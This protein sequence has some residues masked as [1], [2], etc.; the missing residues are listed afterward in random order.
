VSPEP[1]I[2]PGDEGLEPERLKAY[3][4]FAAVSD[5]VL[6]KLAPHVAEHPFHAGDVLLR[7]GAYSDA[8]YYVVSGAVEVRLPAV[9]PPATLTW[10][11]PSRAG[12]A[13][14]GAVAPPPVRLGP[15]EIVGELGALSRYPVTADVVGAEP[16][17]VLAIRTP[18]L[19]MMLKQPA[20]ADFR[21]FVEDR[22]RSRA[23]ASHLRSLSLF[24]RLD[25]AAIERLRDAAA[26]R[27]YDPGAAIAVQGAATDALLLVRGGFVKV[28]VAA[29]HGQRAV[30]YLRKGDCAGEQGLLEGGPWPFSLE[31]VDHVEIVEIGRDV[32]GPVAGA[33]ADLEPELRRS[34]DARA[35]EVAAALDDPMSARHL[36]MALETGLINGES[37]LLIDQTR[38]TGCDDCLRACADAHDGIPL[39]ARHGR[40]HEHWVVAHACHQCPDPV[41][42][43]GCPTGAISRSL[44]S[45]EVTIDEATCIGCGNCAKRCPWDNILTLAAPSPDGRPTVKPFK[46]DLCAGRPAGPACVQMCPHDAAVR[47]SFR[48]PAA[49]ARTLGVGTRG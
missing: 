9:L 49:L 25:D 44:G 26:L 12:A 46:C 48:D 20:L 4:L 22:Y 30:T 18:A 41:C 1:R 29:G 38:C 36:Q 16:G 19:R 21:R 45:L 43:V 32:L 15:G 47:V 3:P 37:V 24:S 7:L 8:A 2:P 6:R 35:G 10:S 17:V 14:A 42:M 23:L 5:L 33:V 27:S 40:R 28:T 11:Q 13:G 39:F 34:Q 31:A